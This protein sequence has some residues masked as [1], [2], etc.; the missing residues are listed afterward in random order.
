MSE[1]ILFMH[2]DATDAIGDWEAYL[3]RLRASGRFQGGSAIETGM[4]VRKD[5]R[6]LPI[7]DHLIGYLRVEA[8]DIEDAKTF[9]QGNP[10]YESGG[11]IEIRALPRS[12]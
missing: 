12:D 3:D 4:C 2:N 6:R 9:L 7:T 10:H 8:S 11:T 5:D 1:F